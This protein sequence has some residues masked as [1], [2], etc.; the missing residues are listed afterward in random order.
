MQARGHL[1]QQGQALFARDV[2][3]QPDVALL[4]APWS[5]NTCFG[6]SIPSVVSCAMADPPTNVV[7]VPAPLIMLY[8]RQ[9]V[10][11]DGSTPSRRF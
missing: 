1:R 3:V 11:W 2:L 6:V 9:G 10:Q 7:M 8:I 5:W 4:V